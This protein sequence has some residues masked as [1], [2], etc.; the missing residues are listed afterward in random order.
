MTQEIWNRIEQA[1]SEWNV[2]EHPFYQRW[3]AGELSSE[4]LAHYSGQYRH[5]VVA[6]SDLSHAA[7]KAAPEIKGLAGHAAEE[8]A[9]IDL[10]D[11][12]VGAVDG[13]SAAAPNAETAECI[14]TWTAETDLIGTMAR[15]F[16]IESGQPEISA[17]K[18]EG[19]DQ[20]YDVRDREGTRYFTLHR[21]RDVEHAAEARELIEEL[22]ADGDADRIVAEAE[23][24]F[25]ANWKLLDGV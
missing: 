23:A 20:H 14:D 21:E 13:D 11:G 4:E 10:W 9:H 17:T 8:T 24:A 25:K 16:A 6:I 2:L 5:A 18:L 15:L 3:S 12:F 1:R 22:A 7:A 19:L